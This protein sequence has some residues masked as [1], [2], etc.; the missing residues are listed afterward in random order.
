MQKQLVTSNYDDRSCSS[1]GK[2]STIAA[3]ATP[4]SSRRSVKLLAAEAEYRA[5]QLKAKQAIERTEEETLIAKDEAGLAMQKSQFARREAERELKVASAKLSVWKESTV[6]NLPSGQHL[7]PIPH[8]LPS[9]HLLSNQ[10]L[11]PSQHLPHR[12]F[13]PAFAMTLPHKAEQSQ[14]IMKTMTAGKPVSNICVS[15]ICNKCK[16]E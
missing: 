8:Q 11:L 10:P 12:E 15:T 2:R 1:I 4:N 13:D 9:Q 5:A 6:L 14:T 3:S 7:P 16:C